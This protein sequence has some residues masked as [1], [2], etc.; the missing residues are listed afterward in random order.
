MYSG[1][2]SKA[3]LD[4][5][6]SFI[7]VPGADFNRIIKLLSKRHSTDFGCQNNDTLC[8]FLGE[9]KDK[10]KKLEPIQI[11]LGDDWDFG[12]PPEDYM[13]DYEEAN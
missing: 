7:S 13:L 12:V 11:Q 2:T 9:C 3:I 1:K 5:G 8:F 10:I 4:S 6:T